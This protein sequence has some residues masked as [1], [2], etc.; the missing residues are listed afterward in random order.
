MR[1]L[2]PNVRRLL[3]LRAG[4]LYSCVARGARYI[5]QTT[6]FLA[7]KSCHLHCARR[8]DK[9]KFYAALRCEAEPVW[10][11]ICQAPKSALDLLEVTAIE[12]LAPRLNMLPGG[13]APRPPRFRAF[14]PSLFVRGRGLPKTRAHRRSLSAVGRGREKSASHR[15]ALSASGRR[16]YNALSPEERR[17]WHG[18][19]AKVSN[20]RRHQ[21]AR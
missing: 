7:R 8:G 19:G 18:K 3:S 1:P 2:A 12:W 16:A 17:E 5:G 9:S 13:A 15:A 11:V 6:D 20:V 10:S 4:L 21:C 14:T